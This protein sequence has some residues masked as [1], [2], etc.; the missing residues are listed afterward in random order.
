MEDEV[1]FFHLNPIDSLAD[2]RAKMYGKRLNEKALDVIIAD[3][4]QGKYSNIDLAAFI[5][6]CAGDNLDITEIAALTKAMINA[7][8]RIEWGKEMVVDKHC[9]GGLPGNRTTPIIVSI[10]TAAGLTIPKTSSRAITSPAGTADTMEVM[11]PVQLSI[12][13]IKEVVNK[14]GGCIAW[15]GGVKLSPADDILISVE[16]ALDV[17]SEGQ[18]IASVLSKKVAAGSTHVVID[19]P[20][21]KT[22]KVRT[23]DAALK[24][25][26]YFTAVADAVGLFVKVL[27]TE[28]DQPVG[29]GIGPALEAMDVLSVLRGN[30]DAPMDLKDRALLIAGTIL[31]LSGKSEK[32]KGY[33]NAKDILES[34]LAYKK[35]RAICEA[36]G[37]FAEPS[38]APFSFDVCSD[39]SGQVKEI[40]NRRLAK[41]AKLAGAPSDASAG[42]LF[43]A[44]LN[45]QIKNGQVLFTIYSHTEG[46]MEY[47]VNYLK[48]QPDIIKIE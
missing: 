33:E 42:V 27:L 44:P 13:K 47:A 30:A 12:E 43:N 22:A 3:I 45:Y 29:R 24:L 28:G 25:K 31:E 20:Y 35:F 9:V 40:D 39:R 8:S 19:I 48:A 17:D 36:Q 6:A 1:S 4:V 37:G 18:L 34:G 41:I 15:G 10:L 14:V 32:G 11:A 5:S 16:R 26:Y 46:G 23:L 7:G 38:F 21:G 2:V